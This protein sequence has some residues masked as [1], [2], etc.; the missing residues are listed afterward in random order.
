MERKIKCKV[1]G[2]EIIAKNTLRRY[3]KECAKEKKKEHYK[4]W[5]IHNRKHYLDYLK[6]YKKQHKEDIKW[7]MNKY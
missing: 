3:C 5:V 1:C 2:V 4:R 6:E 7:L